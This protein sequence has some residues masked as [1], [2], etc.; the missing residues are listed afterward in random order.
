MI[1]DQSVFLRLLRT[2]KWNIGSELR[3]VGPFPNLHNV[4]IQRELS[5][6]Y[7]K[8]AE[9]FP[10]QLED[11]R[12][13]LYSVSNIQCGW[14]GPILEINALKDFYC[15]RRIL[16]PGFKAAKDRITLLL[17]GNCEGDCKLRP[18]LIYWTENT[19]A[20]KRV[21]MTKLPLI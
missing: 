8:V 9:T 15:G 12:R 7:Q 17:R 3:L 14:D 13:R 6:A 16:A 11:W 20:L 2:I 4:K 5:G 18:M 19:D 10:N 21:D 1:R